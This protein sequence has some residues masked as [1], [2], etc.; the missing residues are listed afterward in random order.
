MLT[1]QGSRQYLRDSLDRAD[2]DDDPFVQ[3]ER[4]FSEADQAELPQPNAMSLATADGDG[5]PSLRTVLLKSFDRRGFVFYTNHG[6]RKAEEIGVNP[7]VAALLA[8]IPLER[9]IKIHGRAERLSAIDSFAYF[10]TRPRGSQ[11]GAWCSP[12]SQVI[13]D[14]R[15]LEEK[16]REVTERFRNREIPLPQAWG[17]YRIVPQTIE[18]WQGRQDRLHDR[19][20]Y[21]QVER[22]AD[23]VDAAWVIERLAP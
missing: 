10:A 16:L 4:W 11:L 22:G 18:F 5:A 2:L 7:Q 8:W 3:F 17:G 12:Q 1:E 19:F 13:S 15:I 14:R 21:R 9:Q 23:S 20:R 6:S